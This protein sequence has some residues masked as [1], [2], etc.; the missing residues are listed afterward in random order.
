MYAQI[1]LFAL[2]VPRLLLLLVLAVI[3]FDAGVR[4][5]CGKE[6]AEK[7]YIL[8]HLFFELQPVSAVGQCPSFVQGCF[9]ICIPKGKDDYQ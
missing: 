8:L 5:V 6:P 4:F 7:A 2:A 9:R 1:L 3:N